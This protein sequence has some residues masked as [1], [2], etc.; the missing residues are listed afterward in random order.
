MTTKQTK[1]PLTLEDKQTRMLKAREAKAAKKPIDL[2]KE[3]FLSLPQIME[4]YNVKRSDLIGLI[5][6]SDTPIR[7]NATG[8]KVKYLNADIKQL[9]V[10]FQ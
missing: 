4:V 1:S 6:V 3:M 7:S 10:K 2:S 5:A 8:K 9:M